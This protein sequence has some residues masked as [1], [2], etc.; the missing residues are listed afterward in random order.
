LER[1]EVAKP[2]KGTFEIPLIIRCLK[3]KIAE[4]DSAGRVIRIL[5]KDASFDVLKVQSSR[6]MSTLFEIMETFECIINVKS[7]QDMSEKDR[8]LYQR[9]KGMECELKQTGIFRRK[10]IFTFAPQPPGVEM[11]NRLIEALTSDNELL[12]MI[13]GVRLEELAISLYYRAPFDVYVRP[14]KEKVLAAMAEYYQNPKEIAWV[15]TASKVMPRLAN[16]RKTITKIYNILDCISKRVREITKETELN[17]A[18][19]E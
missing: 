16:Y 13:S 5:P 14:S 7:E 15:V 4:W 2:R 12:N 8:R 19:K 3:D 6:P 18:A 11:D 9:L 10:C 1:I 17:E